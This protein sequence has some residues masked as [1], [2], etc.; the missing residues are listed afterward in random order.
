GVRLLLAA[1]TGR[2]AKRM[3]EATGR[4]AMTIHRLLEFAPKEGRF[5]RNEGHPLDV[6]LLVLDEASMIDIVLMNHLLAALPPLA[7]LLLLGDADQLPSV[8]PGSVLQDLVSAA[9]VPVVRLTE[10]F[11]QAKESSIVL[12][13]HRV[14][15][16]ELPLLP[17]F[18][19]TDFA[20]IE[21]EES[22]SIRDRL[23]SLVAREVPKRYGLDPLQ[24]IQV[25]T[26]MNRGPIGV[27]SLNQDLQAVLNPEG[28]EIVLGGRQ[29]RVGD[30]VMQ[31]RNN[32]DKEVFNGD[33]GWIVR[34]DREERELV[35]RFDQ[36][37]V[38]YDWSE[39]DEL[40]LAYAISVHKSQGSEYPAVV[41]P[42]HTSHYVM[43]QR[44]LL[45]TT[46]SRGRRLVV[47]VG[48]R[49]AIA[50]AVRNAQLLKRYS[51]LPA[52]LRRHVGGDGS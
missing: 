17:E 52:R 20:F 3:V 14:N 1:P 22:Q 5:K 12:N 2:A 39:L 8:G 46:L 31:V 9:S 26:P 50:I 13:A 32:Y 7:G 21:L 27:S 30:R 49:Q 36:G 10:I 19:M 11:R 24:D 44:N 51:L 16:G 42:L 48:T 45:Y 4:D 29:L 37:E 34:I 33:L 23:K 18:G 41:A 38:L 35:V 6:D 40:S 28:E 15:R 47:V 43:L 25:I